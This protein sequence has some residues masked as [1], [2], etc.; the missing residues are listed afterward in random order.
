MAALSQSFC[1]AR[2][3]PPRQVDEA[4][5]AEQPY[6]LLHLIGRP[7]PNPLWRRQLFVTRFSVWWDGGAERQPGA[8]LIDPHLAGQELRESFNTKDQWIAS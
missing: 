4:A 5:F 8:A 1:R 2:Q 3:H 7:G 6:T